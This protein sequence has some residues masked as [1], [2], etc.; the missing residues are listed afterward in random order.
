MRKRSYSVLLVLLLLLATSIETP[1]QK[2]EVGVFAGG[3][4][5][6]HSGFTVPTLTTITTPPIDPD[7][8]PTEQ[9]VITPTRINY[10]LFAGGNFGMRVRE[11]FWQHFGF[12]Q[13]YTITGTNNAVFEN[14][15][16][17]PGLDG[18]AVGIRTHQLYFNANATA[19][20][21]EKR[22][23][24]YLTGGFGWNWFNPTDEGVAAVQPFLPVGP[25]GNTLTFGSASK[26]G[27]NFGGGA[28]M[29]LGNR[30][31]LD[32]SVRDFVV[33]SPDFNIPGAVD[34]DLD[35]NLQVQL[36]L[37]VLFGG[38]R[39][40]ITHA[41]T[42][43]PTIEAA[44]TSLCPGESTTLRIAASDSIAANDITYRWTAGGRQVSADPQYTFVAPANAGPQDVGVT[45]YYATGNLSKQE[46]KAVEK[47]R[48]TP[49]DRK[50]VINVKEYRPPTVTASA[51]QSTIQRGERV[52]LTAAATGSECSGA[53]TYR[54]SASD[55]RLMASPDSTS[56]EFDGSSMAFNDAIQGQQCK[57]VTVTVDVTDQRGG[58]AR[59]A[60]NLQVCYT[61]PV[62]APP[63][64]PPPPPPS[65]IQLSDINF[66][67]NSS[68]VNNCAKRVLGNELYPQF[69]SS[70][71]S[72]YD[73][74]LVGHRDDSEKANTTTKPVS[75][76]DRDR[77]LNAAAYLTAGGATCKDLER[78]RV[79]AVWGGPEQKNE[80][81][82]NFC[83]GS[84]ASATD[85]KAKNRRVEVWLVP[86]GTGLP[87]VDIVRASND[88]IA[89]RGC[90]K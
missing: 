23:R 66:G 25:S 21:S 57:P 15:P 49:V 43:A 13:S 7:G 60:K 8:L 17:I 81:R 30:W 74:V 35:N 73:V 70:R 51:A 64:P 38:A 37:N 77:A 78:T 54:W 32:F 68:R 62:A 9:F 42:V 40:L 79:R 34:R 83:D 56:A 75:T 45:V 44:Q 80:F 85:A 86:K 88:D 61:A 33:E 48:Y 26:T 12:E 63:P 53:L 6:P 89:A 20:T 3:S 10:N 41:F 69:T 84:A 27:W 28:R 18:T 24:P 14:N 72:D 29:R 1:A 59:D 90:P 58:V 46:K 67:P 2:L 87:G 5:F 16:G 65:A 31:G 11:N 82:S 39:T 19:F 22:F 76:L 47:N 55:G 71:Y 52:R 4:W 36:G 50:I